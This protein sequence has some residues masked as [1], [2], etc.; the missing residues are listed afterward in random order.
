MQFIRKPK[1]FSNEE[2][3][4]MKLNLP[5]NVTLINEVSMR[6]ETISSVVIDDLTI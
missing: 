5:S 1:N 2:L 4:N 6:L 3:M